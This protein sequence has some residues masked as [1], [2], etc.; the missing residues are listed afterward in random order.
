MFGDLGVERESGLKPLKLTWEEEL[1]FVAGIPEEG[2]PAEVAGILLLAFELRRMLVTFEER[3]SGMFED[4]DESDERGIMFSHSD[5]R[6]S[7][8]FCR[9][10]TRQIGREF[11]A[12][13]KE[14]VC[15]HLFRRDALDLADRMIY[16]TWEKEACRPDPDGGAAET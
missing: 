9:A 10:M 14:D 3:N 11:S 16:W 12:L 5:L 8:E 1:D 15:T 4:P 13:D 2:G 6:F 7:Y